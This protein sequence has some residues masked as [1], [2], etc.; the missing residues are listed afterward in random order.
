MNGHLQVMEKRI[1]CGYKD[2]FFLK[3]VAI[4]QYRTMLIYRPAL[5]LT[6]LVNDP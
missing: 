6:Y 3:E 4:L 5:T 2:F 1:F